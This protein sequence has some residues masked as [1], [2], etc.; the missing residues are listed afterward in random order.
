MKNIKAAGIA[1]VLMVCLILGLIFVGGKQKELFRAQSVPQAN[2]T[3]IQQRAMN[4][5]GHGQQIERT[6]KDNKDAQK[7]EG[8][9]TLDF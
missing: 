4:D 3:A 8:R 7:Q 2:M 6:A 1:A 9:D 5:L